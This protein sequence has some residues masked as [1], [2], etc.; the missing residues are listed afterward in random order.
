MY[1]VAAYDN[2]GVTH[3]YRKEEGKERNDWVDDMKKATVFE[4][5]QDADY[6]VMNLYSSVGRGNYTTVPVQP[7]GYLDH[8]FQVEVELLPKTTLNAGNYCP[9]KHLKV[10]VSIISE[11]Q[12]DGRSWTEAYVEEQEQ[13]LV[14]AMLNDLRPKLLDAVKKVAP[15]DCHVFKDEHECK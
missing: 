9:Q 3:W 7:P 4:T 2:Q 15:F 5:Q 1:K 10:G 13:M 11:A 14:E 6:V 12:H 8:K